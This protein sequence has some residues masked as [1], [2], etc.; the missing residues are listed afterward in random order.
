MKISSLLIIILLT[1]HLCSRAQSVVS[2]SPSSGTVG[3]T[4]S[5]TIK[6]S[7]THFVQAGS[8]TISLG[9]INGSGGV[10][11]VSPINDSVLIVNITIPAN[12]PTND[13]DIIITNKTD[14]NVTAYNSFFVSG[15]SHP[16]I[17]SVS[18]A[19]G[20]KGQTLSVRVKGS[21]TNFKKGALMA[22]YFGFAQGTT[23]V[24]SMNVINDTVVD[25]N[26]TIPPNTITEY[27]DVAIYNSIDSS[28]TKYNIFYV[29]GMPKP[30][31]ISVSPS[32]GNS[33]QTLD[34]NITGSNTHFLQAS[35]MAYF[36][37]LQTGS[38]VNS[39]N[40]VNDSL[41]IANVSIPASAVT[42]Y[43]DVSTNDSIDR[44]ISKLNCFYVNGN[45]GPVITSITPATGTAGETLDITI[46]AANTHFV[47]GSTNTVYFVQG[48]RSLF[49][50]SFNK[51]DDTTLMVNITVPLNTPQG[52][53]N[54]YIF[55]F[56]D[57]GITSSDAFLV[58]GY[59]A[60]SEFENASEPYNIYPNP[61]DTQFSI[62]YKMETTGDVII[63]LYDISGKKISAIENERKTPGKYQVLFNID[64]LKAGFYLLRM[65]LNHVPYFYKMVR[66]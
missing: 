58:D 14:G 11:F 65:E 51:V 44:Y 15:I 63:D 6:G 59:Y 39:V 42:G 26:V 16:R 8:N 4:L 27:Y 41:L 3:Q 52:Y 49:T 25:V 46:K 47:S 64:E 17:T 31:L 19:I 45:P 23:A 43:Y 37:F 57:K 48:N 35:T 34:V 28:L 33:G 32:S 62:D 60:I 40:V 66:R 29:N 1:F 9:F 30:K 54:L 2:V 12:V 50:N 7:K 38:F 13:Y 53:Y 24:N 56:T 20:T 61:F 10:N 22:V 55:N 18:P 5:L 36:G 21:A